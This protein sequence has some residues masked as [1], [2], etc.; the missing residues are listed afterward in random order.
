MGASNGNLLLDMNDFNSY[1]DAVI[2]EKKDIEMSL[3]DQYKAAYIL[4]KTRHATGDYADDMKYYL[5]RGVVNLNQGI[6]DVLGSIHLEIEA[7]YHEFEEIESDRSGVISEEGLAN[8]NSFLGGIKGGYDNLKGEAFGHLMEAAQYIPISNVSFDDVNQGFDWTGLTLIDVCKAIETVDNEFVGF[9]NALYDRI[10]ML[11]NQV[12]NMKKNCFTEDGYFNTGCISILDDE[13]WNPHLPSVE[14]QAIFIEHPFEYDEYAVAVSSDQWAAGLADDV[15]VYAGYSYLSASYEMGHDENGAFIKGKGSLFEANAYAQLTDLLVAQ[16]GV[17]VLFAEG[18]AKVGWGDGYYGGR[19]SV[20][21]GVAEVEASTVLGNDA[22]GLHAKGYAKAAC[23]DA[24]AYAEFE[25]EDGSFHIGAEA[26]ATAASA[27]VEIGLDGIGY[28]NENDKE[29][30]KLFDFSV[31][32]SVGIEAQVGTSIQGKK[33]IEGE[34]ANINTLTISGKF[35]AMLGIKGSVT[36]PYIY[37]KWDK[38]GEGIG[39]LFGAA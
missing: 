1:K 33:G 8:L 2:S 5:E 30:G 6:I 29:N 10:I 15:Y 21:V 20:S 12:I 31:S 36:V 4:S 9:A 22:I 39:D 3:Y 35:A 34:Y 14:L 24:G 37:P 25:P 28:S 16:A 26:S 38:I 27:G 13:S 19:A 11:K 32:P 18:E 17:K 7:C 23:A